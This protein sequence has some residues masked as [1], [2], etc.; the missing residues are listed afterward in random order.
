MA[1]EAHC[2]DDLLHE[3]Q[4][5]DADLLRETENAVRADA[6]A[7]PRNPA[8]GAD[9]DPLA[10]L[11]NPESAPVH[12]LIALVNLRVA[13][14]PDEQW[15]KCANC[16]HVFLVRFGD[17]TVCSAECWDAYKDCIATGAGVPFGL[18]T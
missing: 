17:G 7:I 18:W 1:G 4:W 12:E 5:P 13:M 2:L 3:M 8:W 6:S 15:S 16:G 10:I 11:A 9:Y 14:H